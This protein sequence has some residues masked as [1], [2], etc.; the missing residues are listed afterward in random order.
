MAKSPR[1]KITADE[2]KDWR[3][4]PLEH[5]NTLSV[6]TMVADLNREHY[7]V[8][9]YVPNRGYGYEQGVIKRVLNEYGAE[10]VRET[11][12]RS[13]AEYRPSADYPQ[14]TAGFLLTYMLPRI[15][16]R[17]LAE[18]ETAKRRQAAE[19]EAPSISELVDWL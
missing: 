4:L 9:K 7:G 19:S 5:W 11:I 12:E 18:M 10:A 1:K 8:E 17:V 16:P 15:M 14:L 2:R 6:Q 13:F 3:N